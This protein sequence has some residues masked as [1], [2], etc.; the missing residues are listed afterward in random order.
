MTSGDVEKYMFNQREAKQVAWYT[1]PYS[2]MAPCHGTGKINNLMGPY[3][4]NGP[5]SVAIELLDTEPLE[6][7]WKLGNLGGWPGERP[8]I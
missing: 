6:I 5:R 2:R 3:C 7:S 1:P 8:K 4:T